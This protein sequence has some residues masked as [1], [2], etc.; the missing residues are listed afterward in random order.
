MGILS[1]KKTILTGIAMIVF[2]VVGAGLGK[3]DGDAAIEMIGIGLGF[4]FVRLG[5]TKAEKS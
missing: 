1:G 2:A 3:L 5:I 4:I